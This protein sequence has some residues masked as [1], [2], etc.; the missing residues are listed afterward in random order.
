MAEALIIMTI[1]SLILILEVLNQFS[2]K[3][4]PNPKRVG[5]IKYKDGKNKKKRRV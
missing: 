1:V 4:D 5:L 2:S 3:V